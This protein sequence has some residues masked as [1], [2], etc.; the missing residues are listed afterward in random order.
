MKFL[1]FEINRGRTAA[2]PKPK[3]GIEIGD[4]GTRILD[5]IISEE[6]NAK[7][8]DTQGIVIYDEMRK[9]DGTVRA[10]V[11]AVT[12]P[13]RAAE[14]YVKSASEEKADTEIADFVQE[15]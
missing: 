13:I 5:G 14:W 6:Y 2:E 11:Q 4:T 3:T 8:R 15:C 7:L 12:L 1:G 9:S 10:A